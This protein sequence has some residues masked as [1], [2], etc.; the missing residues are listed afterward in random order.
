MIISDFHNDY[1]TSEN[2]SE[3]G[4]KKLNKQCDYN[5]FA[6]Y[7]GVNTFFDV[8][9]ICKN[10]KKLNLKNAFL[11]FEDVDYIN[12]ENID[13]ILIYNPVYCSLT[14][15]YENSLAYGCYSDGKIKSKG[16]NICK[17]LNK[18]GV[19]IDTAHLCKK[20]FYGV[21]DT[22]D[23]IINSHTCFNDFNYHL[24]NIDDFQIKEIIKRQGLIGVA[25]VTDFLGGEKTA[26]RVAECI[27]FFV[28]K[29]GSDYICLG[30]DFF[31]TD[32][33]PKDLLNYKMIINLV[34]KLLKIG[35]NISVIEKITYLNLKNFLFGRDTN[36]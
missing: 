33:L 30:T 32:K 17:I 2:F 34:E 1:L 22:C 31:G 20:S 6:V 16:K 5:V 18:N 15:N 14:W 21:I 4:L 11:A 7:K 10:Y 26:K 12:E 24:R 3:L 9:N 13:D 28:Q 25:F 29:Y 27:D 23:K 35:Y 36:V 19:Y 8:K